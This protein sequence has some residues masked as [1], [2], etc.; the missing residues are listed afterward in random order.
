MAF[1]YNPACITAR[2]QVRLLCTDTDVLGGAPAQ[3]FQDTEIDFFLTAMSSSVLRAAAL[4]LYTIAAQEVLLMKRI[5]LLDISTDGPAEATALRALA[6]TY[7]EKAALAEAADAGGTFDY[8]EM[9]TDE[10][11]AE[12]RRN[13]EYLRSG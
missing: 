10:A 1:N 5:R 12:E 2:D 8:A 13:K 9:V 11:T 4:A 3:Y 7:Q 6:D